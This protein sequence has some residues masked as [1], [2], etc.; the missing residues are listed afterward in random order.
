MYDIKKELCMKPVH[1]Q[2]CIYVNIFE[3]IKRSNNV[4]VTA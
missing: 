2:L 3:K 4:P 1:E